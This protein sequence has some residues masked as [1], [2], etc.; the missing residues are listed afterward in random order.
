MS[1]TDELTFRKATPED[2]DDLLRMME[3][4]Y[5]HDGQPFDASHAEAATVHLMQTPA[6]GTIWTLQSGTATAGYLVLTFGYS[7]EFGGKDALVDELYLM[8]EYRGRGWGRRALEFAFD[9]CRAA[10][11]EAVHVDVNSVNEHAAS[12]YRRVGFIQPERHRMTKLL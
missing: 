10:G 1:D 3:Q 2:V 12:V 7:L 11:V 8:P 5:R 9:Q 4:L 6:A